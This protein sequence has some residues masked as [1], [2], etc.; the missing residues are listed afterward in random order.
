MVN[1][2]REIKVVEVN[3][4]EDF[5]INNNYTHFSITKFFDRREDL[6]LKLREKILLYYFQP[7]R[8]SDKRI[9]CFVDKHDFMYFG[10]RIKNESILLEGKSR[11]IHPAKYFRNKNLKT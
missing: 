11:K 5:V 9:Y 10:G 8:E 1:K 3:R 7:K 2:K 4:L 6:E